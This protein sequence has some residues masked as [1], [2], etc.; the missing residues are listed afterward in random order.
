MARGQ[1]VLLMNCHLLPQ[2][3]PT[4]EKLIERLGDG[5]PGSGSGGS[6]SA[7]SKKGN[8][9]HADFRLWL[10]TEPTDRFPVGIL[11]QSYKLVV[12]P[13]NGLKFNLKVRPFVW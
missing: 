3:L 12:E 8:G 2:W 11:Q 5:S 1:W 4:L 13:P 9:V 6:G 10:T 7:G